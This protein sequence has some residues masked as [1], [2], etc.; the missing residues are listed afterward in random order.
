MIRHRWVGLGEGESLRRAID[1]SVDLV[2]HDPRWAELFAAERDRLMAVFPGTFV[3]IAHIGSTPIADLRAKPIIDLLAGVRSMDV[4]YALNEP[5]C[6][7]GYA[8]S[9]EF[10]GT[11]TDRQ[12]FM[13]HA[14]GRRTHHLHVTVHDSG[15]WHD[16]L[17]FSR[18]LRDDADL[19]DRYEALKSDLVARHADD[20]EAYTEGKSAFIRAAIADGEARPRPRR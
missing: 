20:R 15:A 16:R 2:D 7:N 19:R 11:L 3:E 4:A 14:N 6:R 13:R 18:L 10:N 8:T 5:L 12:F 9:L 17:D 1:Q